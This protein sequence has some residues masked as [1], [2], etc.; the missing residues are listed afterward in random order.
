MKN[1]LNQTAAHKLAK[2]LDIRLGNSGI[3]ELNNRIT[4]ILKEASLRAR[5]AR[6]KTILDRDVTREIDL[7]S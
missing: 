1:L 4:D 5:Q 3:E 6:R 7:F 2:S